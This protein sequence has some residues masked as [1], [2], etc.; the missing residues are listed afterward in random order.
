MTMNISTT[1][2]RL[3]APASHQLP[4]GAPTAAPGSERDQDHLVLDRSGRVRVAT[5]DLHHQATAHAFMHALLDRAP[6]DATASA[7]LRAQYHQH[8]TDLR[9][10]YGTLERLLEEHKDDPRIRPLANEQLY[11]SE[12]LQ[13]DLDVLGGPL[14]PSRAARDYAEHLEEVAGRDPLL[15]HA[16]ARLRFLA[17]MFGGRFVGTAVSAKGLPAELYSYPPGIGAAIPRLRG[18]IDALPLSESQEQAFIAETRL[19]YEKTLALL[20]AALRPSLWDRIVSPILDF[21]RPPTPP[22]P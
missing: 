13:K 16:H 9:L 20:D 12:G 7:A 6:L 5:E 2:P 10:L 21:F 15:L 11:R 17:D 19:G 4:T 22:T 3:V 14:Q 1:A 8:L 18:A